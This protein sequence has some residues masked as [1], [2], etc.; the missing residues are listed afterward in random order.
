VN[1]K[2]REIE[3][4]FNK[5]YKECGSIDS[6]TIEELIMKGHGYLSKFTIENIKNMHHKNLTKNSI[7][8]EQSFSNA[9]S[10]VLD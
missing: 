3:E 4:E 9:M 8:S 6:W 2:I 5:K 10:Y 1:K 7:Q